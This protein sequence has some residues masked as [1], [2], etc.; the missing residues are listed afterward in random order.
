[1]FHV[2]ILTDEMVQLRGCG[3]EQQ[4]IE[5]GTELVYMQMEELNVSILRTMT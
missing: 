2:E 1:V 5:F 3:G 4:S